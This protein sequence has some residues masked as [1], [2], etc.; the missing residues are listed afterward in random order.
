MKFSSALIAVEN[1]EI[2]KKFYTEVL[3]RKIILDFGK[4]VTFEG[5]FCL[6]ENYEMLIG[7]DKN[8]IIK[9][10][11][12]F[13]LYFEEENFDDFVKEFEKIEN[14]NY[15]HGVKE[16]AWGQRVIRFYDPDMHIIEVGESMENVVKRFLKSG[17]SI[18][19]TS[20]RTMFPIEF[21]KHIHS[22]QK[23]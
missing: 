4:N 14:I 20:K 8:D 19:E 23:V 21:V 11:N 15:L 22:M 12:N 6:Q 17:M 9:K 3:K 2:S 16:Y 1:I 10:S 5:D 7:I 18:E 13:E